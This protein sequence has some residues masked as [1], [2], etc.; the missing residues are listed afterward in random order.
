MALTVVLH[1]LKAK[2]VWPTPL[3]PSLRAE[4]ETRKETSPALMAFV[5]P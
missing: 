5:L 3:S 4:K 1:M 2:K